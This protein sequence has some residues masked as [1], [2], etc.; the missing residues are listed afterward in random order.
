MALEDDALARRLDG[1]ERRLARLESA[2]LADRGGSPAA[3]PSP[4]PPPVVAP[5]IAPPAPVRPIVRPAP[6][7]PPRPTIP[8]PAPK[9]TR[10]PVTLERLIGGRW[11]AAIGAVAIVIGLALS[12]KLA[13]DA[14]Y[15]RLPPVG[16]VL[17][18]AGF[19]VVLLGAGEVVLRRFGRAAS[20]GFFGAGVGALFVAAYGAHALYDLVA[21]TPAFA[22]MASAGLVGVVVAMRAN[23][24][25]IGVLGLLGAYLAPVLAPAPDA[26]VYALP[27]YLL[28][29]TAVGVGLAWW[30]R[31]FG[32]V[33]AFA[34]TAT[35]V[36]GTLWLFQTGEG[37]P[38]IALAFI[39]AVWGGYHLERA[40]AVRPRTPEPEPDTDERK[41]MAI[42]PGEAGALFGGLVLTA[43]ATVGGWAVFEEVLKQPSWIVPAAFAVASLMGSI[44]LAGLLTP[45]RELSRTPGERFGVTLLAQAGGLVC[46]AIALALSGWVET[47]TWTVMGVAAIAAGRAVRARSLDVYGLILLGF[48]TARALVFESLV[49]GLHT[50]GHE[51]LGL[52]LTPWTALL[53]G[54]AVSVLVSAR[55]LERGPGGWRG[56]ARTLAAVAVVLVMLGLWHPDAGVRSVMFAWLGVGLAAGLLGRADRVLWMHRFAPLGVVGALG[57]WAVLEVMP[58]WSA[59]KVA[60]GL[61]PGLW[62]ALALAASAGV[63]GWLA[64]W[65]RTP[66]WAG[67]R[68][69][70]GVGGVALLFAASSLEVARSA[71]ILLTDETVRAGA[72]SIWWGLFAVGLVVFGVVRKIPAVRWAGLGLMLVAVGKVV[73]MDLQGT[74]PAVRVASFLGLGLLMVAVAAGY[75]RV[76]GARRVMKEPGTMPDQGQ[77]DGVP[78]DAGAE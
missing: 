45:L 5:P 48:G 72:I 32:V 29:V 69:A 42:A 75:L 3:T 26:S 13:W 41:V 31:R 64:D 54:T 16:R 43:W 11:F 76:A 7:P 47:L 34:W 10:D 1:L 65:P 70:P 39:A 77:T 20:A 14:G 21:P 24:V 66:A 55:L 2:V 4:V 73:V 22:L 12:L 40:L 46:V 27:I 35:T 25:S 52:V 50:T 44:V 51:A 9:A 33:R 60:P 8:P 19:G 67:F 61:H 68:A 63:L 78:P 71:E 23:I 17:A 30:R 56:V 74:S 37:H 57:A 15:L 38:W 28:V 62:E 36:L 49:G 58:G 18:V 53:T 6:T 59:S